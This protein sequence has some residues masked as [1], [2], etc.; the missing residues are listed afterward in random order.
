[1]FCSTTETSKLYLVGSMQTK[2]GRPLQAM[3]K[4]GFSHL[5]SRRHRFPPIE[6]VLATLD[7]IAM[8]AVAA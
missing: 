1:M 3:A 8:G 4:A 6:D 2:D 7:H 5:E